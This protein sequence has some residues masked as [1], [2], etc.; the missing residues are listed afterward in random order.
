MLALLLVLALLVIWAVRSGGQGG[1]GGSD[2]GGKQGGG[3]APGTIT[4]GPSSSESVISERPGGREESDGGTG[5]TGGSGGSGGSGDTDG[6]GGDTAGSAGAGSGG[7]GA[8]GEGEGGAN[9]SGSGSGGSG[10]GGAGGGTA[11][12]VSGGVEAVPADSTIPD[13]RP[14]SV[15]VTLRS[16]ENRYAPGEEPVFRLTVRNGDGGAC[17]VD[18]GTGATAFTI[19]ETEDGDEKVWKS[20][21]CPKG[22]RS[23]FYKVPA[24]G[25][26]VRT[27]E[28]DRRHSTPECGTPGAEAKAGT[29]LVEAEVEGLEKVRTSFVLTKD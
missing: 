5:G 20:E 9:G 22:A 2:Q 29:Y 1:D 4:P 16:E 15:E 25:T 19:I 10:T 13:C 26:A 12:V 17:K 24:G 21:H 6:T 28:W 18:F 27:L 3:E 14:G 23:A 7:G 11:G 8:D